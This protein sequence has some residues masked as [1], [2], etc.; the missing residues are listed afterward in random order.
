MARVT[1]ITSSAPSST[2]TPVPGPGFR[3]NNTWQ[4]DAWQGAGTLHVHT[5]NSDGFA[6]PEAMVNAYRSD[7]AFVSITDHNY[8][9]ANPGVQGITYIPGIEESTT[10]GHLCSINATAETGSLVTGTVLSNINAQGAIPLIVHPEK[11]NG[12][13]T[14][15]DLKTYAK[16]YSLIEIW[17]D[18]MGYQNTN[19]NIDRL[20]SNGT[21]LWLTADPDAHDTSH[22]VIMPWKLVV[23]APSNSTHD[24][25]EALRNGNFYATTGVAVT[26]ITVSPDGHT[27]TI[28]TP[29]PYNFKWIIANG[30][31]AAITRNATTSTYTANGTEVYIRAEITSE[32]IN[33][34]AYTQPMF[35]ETKP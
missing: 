7:S 29:Q 16:D 30:S 1:E 20:L 6:S 32:Y 8:L 19:G 23:N 10:A 34:N 4:A 18:M 35:I 13:W 31:I 9:T 33:Q 21:R 28:T 12:G 2:P 25:V 15:E 27:V 26:D 14:Y 24:I 3:V 17:N 11:G 5:T 22:A